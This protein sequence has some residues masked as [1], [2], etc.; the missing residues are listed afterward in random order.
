MVFPDTKIFIAR[1]VDDYLCMC[2]DK[3]AVEMFQELMHR[4]AKSYNFNFAKG[5]NFGNFESRHI[6]TVVATIECWVGLKISPKLEALPRPSESCVKSTFDFTTEKI[7][8]SD[9]R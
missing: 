4:A 6:A 1:L 5:K 9:I 2:S 8:L 3:D 7:T